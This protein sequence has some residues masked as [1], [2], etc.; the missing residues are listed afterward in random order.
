MTNCCIGN[1]DL[2]TGGR[3]L[4]ITAAAAA[5]AA[6][7]LQHSLCMRTHNSLD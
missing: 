5:A 6:G 3:A 2:V 1:N 4:S 7:T